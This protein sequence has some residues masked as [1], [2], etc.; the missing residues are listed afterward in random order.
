MNQELHVCPRCDCDYLGTGSL[1][2][3]DN[4][5]DICDTCGTEE[6]INDAQP[7]KDW[8]MILDTQGLT[9]SGDKL[10]R[11]IREKNFQTKIGVKFSEWFDWK[12]EMDK[13]Q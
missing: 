13:K 9:T 4:K 1:S 11:M 12:T 8:V 6:A 10:N 7:V 5:T 2:R 3:R